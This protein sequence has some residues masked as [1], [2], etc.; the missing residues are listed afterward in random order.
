MKP[1]GVFEV[2]SCRFFGLQ[3]YTHHPQLLEEDLFFPGRSADSV[4]DSDP[5]SDSDSHTSMDTSPFSRTPF[6]I[7]HLLSLTKGVVNLN[8]SSQLA[9]RLQNDD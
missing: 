8:L 7:P 5:A 3:D 1:G 2:R 6:R 9:C 4:S